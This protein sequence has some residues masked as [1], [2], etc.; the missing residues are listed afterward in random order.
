MNRSYVTINDIEIRILDSGSIL[1][2]GILPTNTL[3]GNIYSK[4]KRIFFKEIIKDGCFDKMISK[5]TPKILL[6]HKADKEQKLLKF[7]GKET[8]KGLRFQAE[9]IPTEELIKNITKVTGLSFAF[10]KKL[11]KWELRKKEWIRTVL[12]FETM[13]E[14]SILYDCFPAYPSTVIIAEDEEKLKK[15][16]LSELK[17]E[18]NKERV[19]NLRRELN[20]LKRGMGR[21]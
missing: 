6:N 19:K 2:K 13:G 17:K 4:E 16:E 15:G 10:T 1:I 9:I 3:S 21:Y 8:K 18:I 11:D 5:R 14:I 7:E 20:S 12:E